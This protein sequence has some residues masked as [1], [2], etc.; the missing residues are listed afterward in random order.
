M[1]FLP[2]HQHPT[3]SPEAWTVADRGNKDVTNVHLNVQAVRVCDSCP[4][5]AECLE[6]G[7]AGRH[8]GMIWG[9]HA[10]LTS[11]AYRARAVRF[12][13]CDNCSDPYVPAQPH[14]RTCRTTCRQ[15]LQNEG[16]RRA[17]RELVAA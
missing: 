11:G 12:R 16:R 8:V 6:E 7:L 3:L 13:L 10:V 17:R 9:G 4:F 15:A 14:Q 5:A 2:C 1:T